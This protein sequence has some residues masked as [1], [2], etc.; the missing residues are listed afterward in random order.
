MHALSLHTSICDYVT[1]FGDSWSSVFWRMASAV[2]LFYIFTVFLKSFAPD[3]GFLI[4]FII[5]KM[6]KQKG[7]VDNEK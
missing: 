2:R 7:A 6:E 1:L 4:V 5:I 3:I